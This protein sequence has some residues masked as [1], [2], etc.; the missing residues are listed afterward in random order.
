MADAEKAAE[1]RSYDTPAAET[2]VKGGERAFKAKV[3]YK[4][5]AP[6]SAS[7]RADAAAAPEPAQTV[8]EN[9]QAK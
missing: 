6:A 8:Y 9:Y 7:P 1:Q 5:A 2:S 4:K 3:G